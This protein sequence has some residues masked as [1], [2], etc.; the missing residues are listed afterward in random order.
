[1]TIFKEFYEVTGVAKKRAK[2]FAAERQRAT[3]AQWKLV[4]S[5]KAK[6]Y[7]PGPSGGIR[8]LFFVEGAWR[9]DGLRKTGRDMGCI[10]F[11][12]CL[13]VKA[14]KELRARLDAA[15]RVPSWRAFADTFGWKGRSPMASEEGR[16]RIYFCGGVRVVKPRERFFLTFPRELKDGW[17]PP[18]GLKL[19][20]ESEML[21]AIE[22]HNIAVNGPQEA[23]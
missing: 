17:K 20:R 2:A 10:E 15:P 8:S 3:A 5:L 6:G 13:N 1:M 23:R 11:E 7:R 9:P 12:P 18:S 16:G 19:V 21:R 14:G 22:D 4:T